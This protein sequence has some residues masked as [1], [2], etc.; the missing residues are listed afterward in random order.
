MP[1][2]NYKKKIK[3]GQEYYFFRLRH[4]N[5]Y[6]PKD[7]YAKT[8]AEL[9]SKIKK[10]TIQLD[11]DVI[12][13]N[14]SFGDFFKNWL[15]DIH[16]Y[17]VKPTT[18]ERYYG[19][20]HGYIENC[21]L[22]D[23]KIQKLKSFDIQNYY[24]KLFRAGKS[25]NIIRNVNILIAPCI[26]YAYNNDV[27]IKDFSRSVILPK[28]KEADKLEKQKQ[29]IPFTLEEQRVFIEAIKG[30]KLEVLY[31]T[32][33]N[34]G[35]RQGELLALTWND[36]DFNKQ[37]IYVNKAIKRV[38]KVDKDGR[39]E[40]DILLQSTKTTTSNRTVPMPVILIKVLRQYKI[41]QFQNPLIGSKYYSNN[42]LVFCN[43]YGTYLVRGTVLKNFKK[44][45]RNNGINPRKFHDLR[46]TYATRLFEL[47]ENPKTVQTLLGHSNVAVTLDTYT[48]VLDNVKDNAV[49]KLNDLYLSIGMK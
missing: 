24:N 29:V 3:N 26:R 18:L 45:L 46:H 32:A 25:V 7:I 28:L 23:I 12:C 2:V 35:L 30:D 5:L 16:S 13:S 8:V 10:A 48:H 21:P 41:K 19:I 38:A 9:E 42:N 37:C 15:F 22:S 14:Q 47:G 1:K 4:E 34:T 33:L 11:N 6:K 44:T 40:S 39:H 49:S 17:N 27:I 20:Y 36:I 43:E 31:L